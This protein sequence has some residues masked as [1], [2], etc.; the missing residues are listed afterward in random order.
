MPAPTMPPCG[1]LCKVE[2][3]LAFIMLSFELPPTLILNFLLWEFL[4][5]CAWYCDPGSWLDPWCWKSGLACGYPLKVELPCDPLLTFRRGLSTEFKPSD[6]FCEFVAKLLLFCACDWWFGLPTRLL[7]ALRR[8]TGDKG[9]LS[10]FACWSSCW[11][12]LCMFPCL[13]IFSFFWV[14]I[15]GF[16]RIVSM[17]SKVTSRFGSESRDDISSLVRW[18]TSAFSV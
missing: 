16:D 10:W 8:M 7:M 14:D 4:V 15:R 13:D 12:T 5:V 3:V 11:V 1:P 17:S 2:S 18:S 6:C 9:F